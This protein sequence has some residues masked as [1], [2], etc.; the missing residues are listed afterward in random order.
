MSKD[1]YKVTNWRQ[2]NEGLK[3][4]GSLRLWIKTEIV[5][6]WKYQG[7]K[8][9]GGQ[10][11]YS[12][13]AIELCLI[14]RKVYHLPLRQTEGF[15]NSFFEQSNLSLKAPDY[16]TISKR[17][18]SLAVDLSV[19]NK[20]GITDIVVD[21][22]GLKVY[23]EGEWKVRKHGAGKHRS[24][25]KMHLAADER[26]QQIQSVTLT[27][28][29]VDDATEVSA[30]LKQI[31]QKVRSF[32]ADGVYDKQKVRKELYEKNIGQ[33]IPPQHNAVESKEE[34]LHL[35][36]RNKAIQTISTI[37]RAEWKKKE[38][39]HQRSKSETA[40]FRYKT[41]VGNTL[42]ARKIEN[43]QVEVRIGCKI[44]NLLL[45]INKPKAIK[46]A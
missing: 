1:K 27:T 22:T 32:K 34:L 29:A 30:L 3:Q 46:V 42:S 2:Y 15:M 31:P 12:D 21:S 43:Q 36:Q 6:Q 19:A 20:G 28:N 4:R 7:D 45:Q 26:T 13:M 41:I 40:M 17:S 5:E 44:L 16:T 33:V 24:W 10:H 35:Q 11:Q 37:G 39:Y 38:D 14:V 18:G 8:K 23:G 25:M 9:R